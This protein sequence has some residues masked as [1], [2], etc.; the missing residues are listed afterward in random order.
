MSKKHRGHVKENTKDTFIKKFSSFAGVPIDTRKLIQAL[1][2]INAECIALYGIADGDVQN[3]PEQKQDDILDFATYF[4]ENFGDITESERLANW[5]EQDAFVLRLAS[6]ILSVREEAVYHN[7]Y[8]DMSKDLR[9]EVDSLTDH[10][11]NIRK[12]RVVSFSWGNG[13]AQ[14][15]LDR[16]IPRDMLHSVKDHLKSYVT[17]IIDGHGGVVVR[18][19]KKDFYHNTCFLYGFKVNPFGVWDALSAEEMK[20]CHTTGPNGEKLPLEK[21][22]EYTS[23]PKVAK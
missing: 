21:G 9:Q 5:G 11:F 12:D 14:L 7:I 23:R 20:A 8:K 15:Y 18:E 16:A 3:I 19:Y 17:A 4:I 10:I 6:E 2:I 1:G 13:S 22:V